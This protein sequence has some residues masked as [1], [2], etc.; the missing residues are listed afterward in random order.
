MPFIEDWSWGY[1]KT[2][3]E[4]TLRDFMNL[5]DS[6]YVISTPNEIG[7]RGNNIYTDTVRLIENLNLEEEFDVQKIKK[8]SR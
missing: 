1:G 6:D 7:I 5:K 2:L 3:E 8:L 4:E